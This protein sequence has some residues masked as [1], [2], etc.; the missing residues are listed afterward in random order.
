VTF[1]GFEWS[2]DFTTVDLIAAS[3]TP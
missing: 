3:T 1:G 2:G